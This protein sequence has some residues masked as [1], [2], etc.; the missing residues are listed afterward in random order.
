M[1]LVQQSL[2][3]KLPNVLLFKNFSGKIVENTQY[4]GRKKTE[5]GKQ[6]NGLTAVKT[7]AG[8]PDFALRTVIFFDIKEYHANSQ[9]RVFAGKQ[10]SHFL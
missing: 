1:E 10:R 3:L 2:P 7:P 4:F 6:K 5:E 8:L 9:K